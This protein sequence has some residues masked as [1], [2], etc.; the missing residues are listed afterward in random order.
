MLDGNVD[1][2]VD[3]QVS[4]KHKV[5]NR[6][7][8][9]RITVF[10]GKYGAIAFALF[11]GGIR[12]PE[13]GIRNKLRRRKHLSCGNVRERAFR[14]AIGYAHIAYNRRLIFAGYIDGVSDKLNVIR[15]DFGRFD[16]TGIV[17]YY[18]LF[19]DFISDG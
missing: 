14:A 15:P 13:I 5:S 4:R 19:P 2:F 1:D 3:E 8:L 18:F 7:Y 9:A 11:N 17:F 6:A 16:Y 10:Y 12:R